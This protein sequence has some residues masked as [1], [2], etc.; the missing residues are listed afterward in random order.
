VLSFG[1]VTG[2]D[3]TFSAC[4]AHAT[5]TACYGGAIR[6]GA[7]SLYRSR[8]ADSGCTSD[9]GAAGGGGVA[10]DYELT[11]RN[12]TLANN[13]AEATATG[14]APGGGFFA[15]V[16]AHVD[17][18]TISGN[19]AAVGGAGYTPKLVL[20]E[21]TVS[22]NTAS[23]QTGGLAAGM[24]AISNSTVVF[25]TTTA[26]GDSAGGLFVVSRGDLESSILFGNTSGGEAND[27]GT[28]IG[29]LFG[30]DNLVGASLSALPPGTIHDDPLLGPLQNNGGL[31]ETHALGE[32]S[33]ALDAGNNDAN[34][35]TDQRGAGFAR[36]FNGRADI[37]AVE[38][39]PEGADTI[40]EN[41]FD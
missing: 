8:I 40:F 24:A 39:Q 27:A 17:Y 28:L 33:P 11:L 26:A 2:L 18:S 12:V 5:T 22:G 9:A 3:V 6:A 20:A 15:R 13:V 14:D 4:H 37:G 30:A 32:G 34:D 35:A 29:A 38:M 25:N 21:S 10:V 23:V 19:A 41:G 7:A 31:T 16:E 1:L 36:V